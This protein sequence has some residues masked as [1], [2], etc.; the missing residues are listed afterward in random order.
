MSHSRVL[1]GVAIAAEEYRK[2]TLVD[3]ASPARRVL[4]ADDTL[5][6]RF[7]LR[8]FVES[9]GGVVREA[10][11][12]REVTA[13][14]QEWGPDVLV[15]DI[16]MPDSDGI[17]IMRQLRALRC[18]LPLLLVT[19]WHGLLKPAYNLG[20]AYGLNV[21]DVIAKPV[22]A[23]HFKAGLRRAFGTEV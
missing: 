20:T 14:I 10:C 13:I 15:L 22:D 16:V 1:S 17:E 5:T 11:S 18:E 6:D 2:E 8:W 4:I 21:I 9:C 23:L 7:V 19:A 12:L 3:R